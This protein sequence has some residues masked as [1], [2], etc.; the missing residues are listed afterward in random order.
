MVIAEKEERAYYSQQEALREYPTRKY[1]RA[2]PDKKIKEDVRPKRKRKIFPMFLL[3][4]IFSIACLTITRYVTINQNHQEIMELKRI[5]EREKNRQ[6]NLK[7]ELAETRDL[8]II[9]RIAKE[10]LG[11]D[12]PMEGQIQLVDLPEREPHVA[13][14]VE[15]IQPLRKT[16][17]EHIINLFN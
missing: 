4:V 2:V 7:V 16:V 9:E 17:V 5:L 10:E 3:I 6:L 12:Y 14:E 1:P 11:M 15:G 8:K 13:V